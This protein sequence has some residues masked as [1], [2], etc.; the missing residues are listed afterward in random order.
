MLFVYIGLLII[1]CRLSIKFVTDGLFFNINVIIDYDQVLI[2]DYEC[3]FD[4]RE[5]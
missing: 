1:S 3:G 4:Y 2:I 5:T